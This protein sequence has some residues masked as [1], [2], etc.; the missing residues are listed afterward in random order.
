M[1]KDIIK[2]MLNTIR[3]SKNVN[4]TKGELIENENLTGKDNFL[5]EAIV[6]M[7]EAVET[8]DPH[9]RSI[10]IGKNTPQ[11]GDVKKTQ[12]EMIIKTIGDQ[13]KFKEDSLTFY[14]DADDITI[15]GALPALN[16]T[17]QFR[18]NDSSGEGVYLFADGLQLTESNARIIGKIRDAYLN[19]RTSL[20]EEGDLMDKLKKS[21]DR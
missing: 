4:K 6:L 16:A 12:E 1:A 14:P 11:F 17:F 20:I 21:T 18:F 19:W 9:S 3:E 15:D 2:S 8:A 10:V 13:V 7:E 5:T